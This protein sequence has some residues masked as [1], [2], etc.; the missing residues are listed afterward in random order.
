MCAPFAIINKLLWE[1]WSK[2]RKHLKNLKFWKQQNWKLQQETKKINGD[3]HKQSALPLIHSDQRDN[4]NCFKKARNSSGFPWDYQKLI[5]K[6][7]V[8][9]YRVL[10]YRGNSTVLFYHYT[11]LL[12]I[13]STISKKRHFSN[14]KKCN[15][16]QSTVK[17]QQ[18]KLQKTC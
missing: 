15:H 17:L 11:A 1:F 2:K 18:K 5:D 14:S 13:N 4:I 6:T 16:T 9:D 10:K 8:N 7:H 3:I 12:K